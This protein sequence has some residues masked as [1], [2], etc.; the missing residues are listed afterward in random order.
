MKKILLSIFA[1]LLLTG[2]AFSRGGLDYECLSFGPPVLNSTLSVSTAVNKPF[3]YKI[4]ATSQPTSYSASGLPAGLSVNTTNGFI[5][6]TPT[7]TGTTNVTISAT[8][9]YGTATGTLAINVGAPPVITSSLNIGSH[10]QG[11]FIGY[12][13]TATNSPTSFGSPQVP[14]NTSVNSS[15]G[16]F[17]G[18]YLS[19]IPGSFTFIVSASNAFGS[20]SATVSYTLLSGAP[21]I[22]SATTAS[23]T[24]GSA[25]SYSITGTRTPTSYSA[26]G[27]PSG[28]SINTST[29]AITGTPTVSGTSSVTISA[30]NSWGTGSAVLALSIASGVSAPV[31]TSALTASG[32]VGSA[33]SYSITG[34][35]SPTSYGATGLPAGLSVNTST[36]AITGTP[37]TAGNTSA[38]ISATNGSGTGSATLALNIA[39]SGSNTDPI[40]DA[41][42]YTASGEL[43]GWLYAGVPG[44][45][46]ARATICSTLSPGSSTTTIQNAYNGCPS[47]QTVFLSGTGSYGTAGS[48]LTLNKSGV[49]IR[50]NG[51]NNTKFPDMNIT[52]GNATTL[53]ANVVNVTSGGTKGTK[54]I[55]LASV[56]GLTKETVFE[57]DMADPAGLMGN[58]PLANGTRNIMQANAVVSIAGNV[59]T[60]RN[61]WIFDFTSANSAKTR[62]YYA[63]AMT[64]QTGLEGIGINHAASSNGYKIN[65][66]G[67][68][69]CWLKGNE[70]TN[71]N[72]YHLVGGQSLNIELRENFFHDGGVGN[73]NSAFNSYGSS[74]YGINSNWKIENNVFNKVF[75]AVELNNFANGFYIGYNYNYG[76]QSQYAG[77]QLVTWAF[78]DG[79][80][81]FNLMNLYE[82]NIGE[83]FGADNYYGGA[84]YGTALRN[85]FSGWNK[86]FNVY[87]DVIWLDAFAYNYNLVGNVLGSTQMNPLNFTTAG[88]AAA[89]DNQTIYRIGMPNLGNCSTIR[90]DC[91][92]NTTYG[93]SLYTEVNGTPG[94][95]DCQGTTGS[96]IQTNGGYP[97]PQ[98]DATLMRW[99]NYD[100]YN[101]AAVWDV[102]A[103]GGAPTPPD[104]TIIKSYVYTTTPSWWKSGVAW[105]PIGPDV[106]GGTG[107]TNG[108]VTKTPAQLCAEKTINSV[109]NAIIASGAT[110]GVF[111]GSS[112]FQ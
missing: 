66:M 58:G 75:P 9:S 91:V 43:S 68:D 81:P 38:T 87:G 55:T 42:K 78:D 12:T 57:V 101:Q 109:A 32:T 80:A 85:H 19:R 69:S 95:G 51:P 10:Y 17:S 46:P 16:V 84:A 73:N 53:S 86:N 79:H 94:L 65:I 74:I 7:S 67:C 107:D 36:G 102:S 52:L 40:P 93:S 106:T 6:G 76:S 63:T 77:T 37:T 62:G 112:C 100:Y 41:R 89:C 96:K 50:G 103:L 111:P 27:L 72:T 45:I 26:T 28:L 48:T 64:S 90:W 31:V 20:G 8:N 5:N 97:D 25:F 21:V 104:Q 44:G 105:P 49:T 3:E 83:T 35:N 13:I 99:G 33:F 34:S 82:G 11:D 47:G 15:T 4:S 59:V 92:I 29:G 54:T 70:S 22:T 110:G 71:T 23:G 18:Q 1:V 108:Y 30:T 98:V 56:T 88:N 24:V 39:A 14:W 61:P 2:A 60:V